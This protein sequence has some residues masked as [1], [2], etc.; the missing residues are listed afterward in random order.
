MDSKLKSDLKSLVAQCDRCGACLTV[1]PLYAV[2]AREKAAARGKNA[3]LR[4]L[5]D[6]DLELD[7]GA[8]GALNYCLLCKACVVNCPC[9]VRTDAAMIMA[10]EYL[11][12]KAG[13]SL[14]NRVIGGFMKSPSL[15][16]FASLAL[17]LGRLTGIA[18][19][20]PAG[21]IPE[22]FTR[23]EYQRL[24]SG[25]A[26]T[27]PAA[28]RAKTAAA[29]AGRPRVAYY[30]GCAMKLFFPKASADSVRVL[31]KAGRIDLL[32]NFCCGRPHQV[33][34]M[35]GDAL[36]L[37]EKNIKLFESYDIVVTD[38]ASCGSA[39]KEYAALFSEN[40]E[41]RI[42]AAVFSKKVRGFSEYLHQIGYE[43]ERQA[44]ITISYHDPCHLVRSQSVK[45]QP[46]A[47]LE[48]AGHFVEA[49]RADMCCGGA[50]TFHL[51]FPEESG[52]ILAAKDAAF[53]QTGAD[54]IVTECPACLIQLAKAGAGGA[55]YKVMHISQ[56][57]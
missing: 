35:G 7:A 23:K 22:E 16:G 44:G 10:R 36:E 53:R 26:G 34:G 56:V 27:A 51:D 9:K 25:P 57:I 20:W 4:V 31:S 43:P 19:V 14:V 30:Q 21:W 18:A 46:R 47:L 48:K 33:H 37:A 1:C 49:A 29:A 11:R 52:K 2:T 15:I 13:I 45:S 54:V 40:S 6:G 39:L 55:C 42:P 41:W 38:C 24:F 50:G 3:I 8:A 32:D 5:L 17:K 12:Q 28:K